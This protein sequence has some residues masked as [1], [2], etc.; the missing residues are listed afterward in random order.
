MNSFKLKVFKPA[1]LI[2]FSLILFTSVFLEFQSSPSKEVTHLRITTSFPLLRLIGKEINVS[3]MKD[4]I[5]VFF[6]KSTVLYYLPYIQQDQFGDSLQLEKRKHSYFIYHKDSSNGHLFKYQED[7]IN[8]IKINADSFLTARGHY[9]TE[10]YLNDSCILI[11]TLFEN[12]NIEIEKYYSKNNVSNLFYHD[13]I[14]LYFDKRLSDINLSISKSIDKL[15]LKKLGKVRLIYNAKFDNLNQIMLPKR[16]MYYEVQRIE[17][18]NPQVTIDFIDKLN[19][20]INLQ[21]A[22]K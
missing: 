11:E 21:L 17:N 18:E 6:Y 9:G 15:K 14:Y 2:V 4:T 22:K 7:S 3:M 8:S 1:I 16:E 20:A 13:S 5:D 19:K 10:F 12:N